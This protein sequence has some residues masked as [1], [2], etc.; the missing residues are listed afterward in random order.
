MSDR[1]AGPPLLL[2]G[3]APLI[4]AVLLAILAMVLV[5]SVAPEKVVEVPQSTTTVD[6]P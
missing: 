2:R 3:F 5:P 6:A 1:P 4:V